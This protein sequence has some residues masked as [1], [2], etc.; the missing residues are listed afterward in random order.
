VFDDERGD[1]DDWRAKAAED[2]L[3]DDEDKARLGLL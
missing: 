3:F 1:G 2:D